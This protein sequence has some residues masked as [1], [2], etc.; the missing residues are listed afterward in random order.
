MGACDAAHGGLG[1]AVLPEA[2]AV[3]GAH[4]ASGGRR[5]AFDIPASLNTDTSISGTVDLISYDDFD[6]QCLK[7]D[8]ALK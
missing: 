5:R 3:A 2:Y 6:L 8:G 1:M 4:S 7:K